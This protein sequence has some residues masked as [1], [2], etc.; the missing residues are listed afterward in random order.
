MWHAYE[1]VFCGF[2]FCCATTMVCSFFLHVSTLSL[3]IP[4]FVQYLLVFHVLLYVFCGVAC[5]VL[6]G[7]KSAL[8]T[9]KVINP[10]HNIVTSLCCCSV[11]HFIPQWERGVLQ[12][13]LQL[14][15]FIHCECYRTSCKTC[16]SPYVWCNS[17]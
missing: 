17:L 10:S 2:L 8:L 3:I 9:S 7:T 13:A 5:L 15:I 6:C 16:N 11:N 1:N 12:L 14:T 4:Q